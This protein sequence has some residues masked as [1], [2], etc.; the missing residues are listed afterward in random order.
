MQLNITGHH[1]EVTPPLNEYV[2]GK[3]SKLERHFDNVTN[4]HV[5]LSVE[6][7]RQKAEA[8]LHVSGADIFAECTDE[9]MY[10][11]IDGLIDK[12]DRQVLKHKEKQKSRR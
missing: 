9:D 11:A 6:K 10:A 8:T 2:T 4:V 3:V 1:V 7:L 12:L 5:V